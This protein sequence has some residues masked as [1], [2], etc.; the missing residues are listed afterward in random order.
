MMKSKKKISEKLKEQAKKMLE[1]GFSFKDIH[2]TLG[3]NLRTLYNMSS[4]E[5]WKKGNQNNSLYLDHIKNDILKIENIKSVKTEETIKRAE[6]IKKK[7]DEVLRIEDVEEIKIKTN[8]LEK[9]TKTN[10]MIH[11]LDKEIFNI[12]TETE[13]LEFQM[14]LSEYKFLEQKNKTEL[15]KLEIETKSKEIELKKAK[16]D[17]RFKEIEQK[18]YD[19]ETD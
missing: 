18:V 15:E 1:S 11:Q 14:K 5:K 10:K 7:F 4:K 13:E 16:I 9:L 2:T 3:I 19:I 6:E 8:S 12:R 17:L